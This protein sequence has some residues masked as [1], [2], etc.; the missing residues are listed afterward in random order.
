MTMQSMPCGNGN[1]E[2]VI[3]AK[4]GILFEYEAVLCL[5]PNK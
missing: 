5:H 1:I 3:P 4:A 2:Y